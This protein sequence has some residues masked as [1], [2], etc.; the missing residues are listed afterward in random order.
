MDEV[1]DALDVAAAVGL[2]VAEQPVSAARW[3]GAGVRSADTGTTNA[4]LRYAA[5][6]STSGALMF[7]SNVPTWGQT[8]RHLRVAILRSL[9]HFRS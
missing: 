6:W 7:T 9:T 8:G 1:T 3:Q 5:A 2:L 4:N